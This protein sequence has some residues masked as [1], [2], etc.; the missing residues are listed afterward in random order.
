MLNVAVVAFAATVTDAGTVNAGDALLVRVTTVPPT[1]A[2]CETVTVHVALPFEPKVVAVQVNPRIVGATEAV[3]T[4]PPV[5][6]SA[7]ACPAND[8]L[9]G[10]PT[11]IAALVD[12]EARV[13]VTVATTPLGMVSEV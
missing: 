9:T 2:A 11:P 10:L 7:R 6:E 5:A 3:V 4:V 8:A 1:G 12:P 13:T